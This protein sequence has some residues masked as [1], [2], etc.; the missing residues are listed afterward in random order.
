MEQVLSL[1]ELGVEPKCGKHPA[2]TYPSLEITK[3]KFGI[4]FMQNNI[5]LIELF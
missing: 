3:I 4:V 5:D 1:F 2:D